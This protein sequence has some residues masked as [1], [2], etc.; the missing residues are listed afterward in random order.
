MDKDVILRP[1][2][3][4]TDKMITLP[5]FAQIFCTAMIIVGGTLYVFWREV[6]S[7]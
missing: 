5:L 2:R 7:L 1:P 3:K 4:A 6:R